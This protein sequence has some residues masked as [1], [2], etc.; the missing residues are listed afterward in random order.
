M[1]NIKTLAPMYSSDGKRPALS[2][3][4]LL[5]LHLFLHRPREAAE[6]SDSLFGPYIYVLPVHFDSHP[7]AWLVK[8]RMAKSFSDPVEGLL[9][10]LPPNVSTALVNLAQR[11]DDDFDTVCNYLVRSSGTLMPQASDNVDR[12]AKTSVIV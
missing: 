8:R 7:L 9:A 12:R 10:F 6:H 3:V 11:F 2:A 5:T 4:Q 1:M